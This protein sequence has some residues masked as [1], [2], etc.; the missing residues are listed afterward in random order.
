MAKFGEYEIKCPE[1]TTVYWDREFSTGSRKM[2]SPNSKV[3]PVPFMP[4]MCHVI[5]HIAGIKGTGRTF[6]F[7]EVIFRLRQYDRAVRETD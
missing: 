2:T 5:R 7:R 1:R 4:A 6:E 3:L